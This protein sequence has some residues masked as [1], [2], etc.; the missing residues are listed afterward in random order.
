MAFRSNRTRNH[1]ILTRIRRTILRAQASGLDS[2]PKGTDRG[3]TMSDSLS[4]AESLRRG[5]SIPLL[6][7]SPDSENDSPEGAV[8][9]DPA[10]HSLGCRAKTMDQPDVFVAIAFPSTESLNWM[11]RHQGRR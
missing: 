11:A 9:N 7:T 8:R 10:A 6:Q 5:W 4:F 1:F 2:R 3:L